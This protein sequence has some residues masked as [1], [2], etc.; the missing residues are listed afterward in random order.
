MTKDNFY[1]VAIILLLLINGGTLLYLWQEKKP[2]DATMR[3]HDGPPHNRV[4]EI[5]MDRLQFN[6][7]QL[8]QFEELKHEHHSQMIAVQRQSSKLHQQLFELLKTDNVDTVLRNNIFRQLE[9][10]DTE[11]ELATFEHFRKLRAILNN[12]QQKRFDEFVEELSRRLLAPLPPKHD[13]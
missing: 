4:D 12:D 3:R 6:N 10:L 8:G 7:E 11:K 13:H 9:V 1:K 2:A 5:I